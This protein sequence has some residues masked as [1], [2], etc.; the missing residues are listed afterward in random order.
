MRE[1]DEQAFQRK[2]EE[3]MEVCF[4]CYAEN[5]LTGTGIKALADACGMSKA[6]LYT[7]FDSLDDLIVQ[8]TAYCMS[9][10]ED[11][12]MRLALTDLQDMER[13]IDEVPYWTAARHGKKYRL[14][15]QVY[16]HPKYIEH[17]KAFFAGVNERYRA[18]ARELEPLLGMPCDVIT[19]LIFIFVR[20][21]V[22]YAL[23]EDEYYLKSEMNVLKQCVSLLS[24]Q[25][26]KENQE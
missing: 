2:K 17:G 1:R 18:Y 12:F 16:T 6:S 7:Y 15:Y 21:S 25:Y 19:P 23:F 9:K 22:H 8:S 5:G 3:I 14:M 10:V 11:D 20:A 26:R 24:S 13:F 4:D